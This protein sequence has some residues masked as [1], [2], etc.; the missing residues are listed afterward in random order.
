MKR[1]ILIGVFV[2]LIS[3]VAG[4]AIPNPSF[5]G[6]TQNEFGGG[7]SFS[8][9]TVQHAAPGYGVSPRAVGVDQFF[10]LYPGQSQE[11][12][13]ERQDFIIQIAPGGC[14]P[15]VVRSDLLAEQ[16]VPVFCEL[17][18]IQINPTLET[19]SI[20]NIHPVSVGPLPEGVLN[21]GYQ[22]PNSALRKFNS[23]Q[24]FTA[25]DNLGYMVVLLK[26]G[27]PENQ[28]PEFVNGT[29]SAR[30]QY[31]AVN[32]FG[33]GL[34]ED[35][36]RLLSDEEW[37]RD[38]VK[39]GFFDGQAYVRLE[40]I[41]GNSVT[42]GI[43]SDV[44]N[45]IDSF[46]V[47]KGKKSNDKYLAASYCNAGYSVSYLESKKPEVKASFVLGSDKFD[48]YKGEKFADG[49]C[50][51]TKITPNV[52]GGSVSVK[53]GG[54]T[55]PLSLDSKP[56]NFVISGE[57]KDLRVGESIGESGNKKIYFLGVSEYSKQSGKE[58]LFALFGLLE[59][60]EGN[61]E[62]QLK[63]FANGKDYDG[64]EAADIGESR[65]VFGVD[66][67]L[68][69]VEGLQDSELSRQSQEYFEDAITHYRDVEDVYDGNENSK[70]DGVVF[71][72]EKALKS[73]SELANVFNKDV[74]Q[75]ELVE[76]IREK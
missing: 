9:T 60:F 66:V 6:S 56:V 48:V 53:C 29:I 25:I 70:I 1:F 14:T 36:L 33:F 31:D 44:S 34:Q 27:M 68:V 7:S 22:R 21:V 75:E 63:A 76:E 2:F 74:T 57:T 51:L 47:E 45:K 41:D 26:G 65:S 59:E 13:Q 61:Y 43:Y 35:Y 39:Y 72:G 71:A 55:Y 4:Q 20:K 37:Q 3:L 23:D 40:R 38:Y 49:L 10:G 42:V 17:Q 62:T 64:F 5:Q 16:N 52:I 30:V 69:G 12:C 73:A 50:T 24:G 32:A 67:E 58:G 8:S 11:Y 15:Q 19:S 18:A 28:M 54:K 46:I